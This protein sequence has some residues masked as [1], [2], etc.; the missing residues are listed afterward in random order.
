MHTSTAGRCM[1]LGHTGEAEWRVGGPGASS[2]GDARH[3]TKETRGPPS[4]RAYR[5][6]GGTNPRER[7]RLALAIWGLHF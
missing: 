4:G 7:L 5:G 1:Q 3:P 6:G 2:R